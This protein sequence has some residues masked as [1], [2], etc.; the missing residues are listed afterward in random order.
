MRARCPAA[1]VLCLTFALAASAAEPQRSEQRQTVA[2]AYP[3]LE[4][5]VLRSATL[6]SLPTGA[7]LR[8]ESL[9]ITEAAFRGKVAK[10][11]AAVRA[12]LGDNAVFLLGEFAAQELVLR[13]ARAAATQAGAS[14]EG[15]SD[16]QITSQYLESKVA[17]VA[18]TDDEVATFYN[19]NRA[20]LGDATLAAVT[21]S[22]AAFLLK[23]KRQKAMKAYVQGLGKGLVVSAPWVKEQAARARANPV[24]EAR[25]S[26]RPSVVD[27][28]AAGCRPCDLMAP[29]LDDLKKKDEGKA[30]VVFVH[31]RQKPALA[32]KYGIASIPTQVF[33]DKNGK[34]M[35]R[36]TGY[37][38]QRRI[39]RKLRE[40]GVE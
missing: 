3:G 12:Q 25:A 34:E 30:N 21:R 10:L 11:P 14:L 22:L 9:E 1:A 38:S 37:Y 24:A 20:M 40:M 15:K 23:Q 17:S 31:V 18:V 8:G 32:A 5:G 28:G 2:S 19:E 39:E 33:F 27:F 13:A 26:G 7:L 6:G 36:H 4:A 35:Y 29:I 16:Q